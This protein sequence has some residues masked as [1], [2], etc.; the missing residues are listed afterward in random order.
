MERCEYNPK[1]GRARLGDEDACSNEATLCVGHKGLW[2]LCQRCAALPQF[3]RFKVVRPLRASKDL[4]TKEN[5][6]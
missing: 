5:E 3:N 1:A 4:T 2:R 6:K